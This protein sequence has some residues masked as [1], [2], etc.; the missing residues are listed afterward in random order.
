MSQKKKKKEIE[1]YQCIASFIDLV[2][3]LENEGLEFKLYQQR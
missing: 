1:S 3:Y 2:I